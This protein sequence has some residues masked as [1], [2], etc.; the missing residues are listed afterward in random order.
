M[1]EAINK[2]YQKGLILIAAGSNK[3]VFSY[4]A[5][6]SNVIGVQCDRKGIRRGS[7]YSITWLQLMELI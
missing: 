3:G 2:A 6:H 5:S 4:P 1:G 7:L